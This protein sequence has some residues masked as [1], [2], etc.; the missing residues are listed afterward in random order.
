MRAGNTGKAG[1][2]PM[3]R[4]TTVLLDADN[5]LFDFDA[6]ERAALERTL[7]E[8]GCPPSAF[9]LERYLSINRALW[10]AF[11]R[12]EVEQPF[13]LTERFRLL[14]EALGRA[15]DPAEMNDAYLTAL[16][17]ESRLLPGAEELCRAL[18]AAGCRL[19]LATNGAAKAQRAR[20]EGSPLADLF[21][22]VFISGEMGVQ[23]PQRAFFD[24]ALEALGGPDRSR[25]VMVGDGLN[26]DIRGGLEAGIDTIWYA[27]GG[28][29]A[30]ADPAPTYTA[31]SFEEVRTIIL[32]EGA[33]RH[34]R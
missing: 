32:E 17:E 25:T 26:S 21:S 9:A 28:Q 22:G 34:E 23:K 5:T 15:W 19:A 30:P 13:L 2:S 16:G 31:R 14:G 4:Y 12:G 20:L 10:A 24:R 27:P 18:A 33:G 29:Q 6:A 1:V 7:G 3:P 8:R 11:D